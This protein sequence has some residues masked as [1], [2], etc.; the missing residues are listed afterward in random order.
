LNSSM[1][2]PCATARRKAKCLG[3][4]QAGIER[5]GQKRK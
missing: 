4:S 5:E 2:Q 3:L 1:V